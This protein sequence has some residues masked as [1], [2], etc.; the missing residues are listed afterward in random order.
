MALAMCAAALAGDAAP[1]PLRI[2]VLNDA[3]AANHPAV[4]GLKAGLRELG[5]EEG[6]DVAYEIRFTRGDPTRMRESAV[7]IVNAKVDVLF[8]SSEAA[9]RSALAS[10]RTIPIVFTLVRDPVASKFVG[11][12]AKPGGNATGI[13]SLTT[14]LAAKRLE[15]LKALAPKVRRVWA[16]FDA[17]DE[18][19]AGAVA[20]ARD[21]AGQLDV[22]LVPRP[23]A[24]ADELARAIAAIRPGEALLVPDGGRFDIVSTL[25]DVSIASRFP[26]VFPAALY[27]GY[28]GLVSYGSD[29]Y[30]EGFQAARLV[31]KI[32][33]G[34]RPGTLPVESAER[35]DL[36][37]NL[38]TARR[39]GLGVPRKILLRADTIRR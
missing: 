31:E 11:S 20:Q 36:A 4:E 38:K 15:F 21:A 28:G 7:A 5:L 9:T 14:Q 24:D 25:L 29:Y 33:H 30:A 32:L 18:V 3:F 16:L 2:G 39:L 19:A 23:V 37:I 34:A 35:I 26:A 13:S 8:T 6:R 12:L 27:V 1:V 17:A 22:Q 10:T